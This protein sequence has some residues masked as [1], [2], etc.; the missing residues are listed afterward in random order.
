MASTQKYCVYT[1]KFDYE[2]DPEK[3]RWDLNS[4]YFSLLPITICLGKIRLSSDAPKCMT[5]KKN[6]AATL[7]MSQSIF[8]V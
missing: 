2:Y 5:R 4:N 8:G 1:P 6:K 7:F 3:S